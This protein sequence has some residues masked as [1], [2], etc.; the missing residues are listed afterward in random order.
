MGGDV[1]LQLALDHPD[2]VAG[3]V[4]ISPGGLALR[5]GGRLHRT[6][7]WAMT[8]LPD[9]LLRPLARFANLFAGAAM[10]ALVADPSSLPPSRGPDCGHW[11][12]ATSRACSPPCSKASWLRSTGCEE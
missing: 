10:K 12:S 4:L 5:L 11:G 1:A 3:L 9:A 2:V 7:V 8:L 6:G